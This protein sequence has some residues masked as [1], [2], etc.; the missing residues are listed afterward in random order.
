MHRL[1][2]QMVPVPLPVPLYRGVHSYEE[3]PSGRTVY[4]AMTSAGEL[5]NAELRRRLVDET[6]ALIVREMWRDLDRQDPTSAR[7]RLALVGAGG[8]RPSRVV[9]PPSRPA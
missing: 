5:L 3:L 1:N 8:F 6:E 2:E 4:Y 9:P 7:P